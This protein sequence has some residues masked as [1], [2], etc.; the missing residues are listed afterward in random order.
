MVGEDFLLLAQRLRRDLLG[1]AAGGLGVGGVDRDI[2]ELGAQ[3]LNLLLDHRP[4]VVGLDD[5]AEAG[6]RWRSPASRPRRRRR[7]APWPG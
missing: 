7:S 4:R 3:A 5:G 1:V 2:D 6:G